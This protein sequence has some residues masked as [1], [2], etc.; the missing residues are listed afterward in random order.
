M[1]DLESGR[2]H[3]PDPAPDPA[4][5]HPG[6]PP[7]HLGSRRRKR[8]PRARLW[9]PI[10]GCDLAALIANFADF[11]EIVTRVMHGLLACDG[12]VYHSINK[13]LGPFACLES[14][15]VICELFHHVSAASVSKNWS[16]FNSF[17]YT[18]GSDMRDFTRRLLELKNKLDADGRCLPRS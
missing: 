15:S 14:C 3:S 9:D 17:E 18:L 6:P 8:V 5:T 7:A 11:L 12:D 1:T 10:G 2:G 13:T 4:R 16:L